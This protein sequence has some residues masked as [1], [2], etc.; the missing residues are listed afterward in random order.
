[1]GPLSKTQ[2]VQHR[3]GEEPREL[4]PFEEELIPVIEQYLAE[5]DPAKRKELLFEYN[6][7]W[8]ENLYT[9]GVFVGRYGL[10]LAKR[11]ENVPVG[12]PV[13]LYTWVE[14]AIMLQQL[15]TPEDQQLEQIRPNTIPVGQPQTVID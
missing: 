5:T 1:M 6:R 15:W 4:L 12:T 10:G 13:F 11:F 8:T 2:P 7:I 9:I 3:E 14:D